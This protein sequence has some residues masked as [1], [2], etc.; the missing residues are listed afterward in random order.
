M[1]IPSRMSAPIDASQGICPPW[2]R[3]RYGQT[4]LRGSCG[5]VPPPVEEHH[6][7]NTFYGC[8]RLLKEYAGLNPDEPSPWAME[9]FITFGDPTP[10]QAETG[11]CLPC[12]LAVT[13]EQAGAIR[14]HGK[15]W[16]VPIG[17]PFFYMRELFHRRHPDEP[18][19]GGANRRGTLVFPDKSTGTRDTDFDREKFARELAALPEEFQPV[20]VSIYFRDYERGTHR[21]FQD[22]G[23]QLVSSGNPCD[24]EFLYRQYDLCRQF[25]YAC[26]N[27]ISTSF[28]LSILAGCEFFHLP[29]G[30]LR[31]TRGGVAQEYAEDPTMALPGK[32]ACLAAAPFPPQGNRLAQ[33]ALAER[34]AGGAH[35][36]PPE[37]FRAL[38]AE[39]RAALS[40]LRPSSLVFSQGGADDRVAQWQTRGFDHDG[41]GARKCR[42]VIPPPAAG[43]QAVVL[44]L[45]IP[46]RPHPDWQAVWWAS[47]DDTDRLRLPVQAGK[48]LLKIACRKDSQPRA[49]SF[50]C[51][52]EIQLFG[53]RR[54]RAFRLT[55][56]AWADSVG[57]EPSPWRVRLEGGRWVADA[58][59]QDTT[60]TGERPS[61]EHLAPWL[62]EGI[63][64][65]GWAGPSCSF[66]VPARDGF[67]GVRVKLMIPPGAECACEG[68][69]SLSVEDGRR[70]THP[71]Q[72]S[73]GRWQLDIPC[74][75]DHAALK[76]SITCHPEALA[77][78]EIRRAL[79]F[80]AITWRKRVKR[81]ESGAWHVERL[82]DG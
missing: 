28:C 8:A 14:R 67:E 15:P 44:H 38:H 17:F 78:G 48:L 65:D 42:L 52:G 5:F 22:A 10:R 18:L 31:V 36:R 75:T 73:A 12:V 81:A 77:H 54:R 51:D 69:W 71:L 37:F 2:L 63:A 47:L 60:F 43:E 58:I 61:P 13:E 70:R 68:A 34:Y 40:K 6:V 50:D 79:R 7:Q 1:R 11:T 30:N 35:V 21:A 41:W 64:A 82:P 45:D 25:R 32:Q 80:T 59:P 16:V 39:C 3:L 19:E 23:L 74:S 57:E 26:A 24:A 4:D 62:L 20:A 9:H 33:M 55:E 29:T 46:A 56:I 49:V 76:V 53:E 66:S 27:D 72:V